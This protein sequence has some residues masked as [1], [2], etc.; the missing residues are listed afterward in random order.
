MKTLLIAAAKGGTGKTALTCQFAH[1]LH[2][3]GHLRVL[4]ID[5]AEPACSTASLARAHRAVVL[6][7]ETLMAQCGGLRR[8]VGAPGLWVLPAHAVPALCL[9]PGA[10]EARYYANVRHLLCV[11]AAFA[12][13]CLI[14]CPPLPDLRTVC[15]ESMVDAM[16]S[17][18]QLSREALDSAACLINAAWGVRN[19]R[20]KL[21]PSLHF[22][23][24]LPNMVEATPLHQANVRTIEA[25]FGAWLIPDP[26]GL[27][28]HL[29][30][31]RF[32]AIAQAQ[33]AGVSVSELGKERAARRAWQSIRACFEALAGQLELDELHGEDH[34][35]DDASSEVE[36]F[37][38]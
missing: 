6:R 23:G 27:D 26:G 21:N 31:P 36:A 5:L 28:R 33:A 4:V 18:I 29:C 25:Q 32:G 34:E 15:V 30:I 20:A 7:G 10:D 9:E 2:L 24:L 13:V 11:L 38:A 8:N 35:R 17:P 12:D 16:V 3:M 14:D 1:Y 22:I 37:H 19:V